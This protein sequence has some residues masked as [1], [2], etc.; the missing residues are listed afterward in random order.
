MARKGK[1]R[2]NSIFGEGANPLIRKIRDV[3]DLIGY[4]SEAILKHDNKRVVYGV[5]TGKKF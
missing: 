1:K 4:N 5:C 2:V 3:L